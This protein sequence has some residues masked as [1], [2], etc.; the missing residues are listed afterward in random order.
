MVFHRSLRDSKSLQVSKTL[1]TALANFNNAVVWIVSTCHLLNSKSSNPLTN[2]LG[3]IPS[4]PITI[5][6]TVTFMSNRF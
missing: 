4:G 3:I 6:I 5:M 1:L 2:H